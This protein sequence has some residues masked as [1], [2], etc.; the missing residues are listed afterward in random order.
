MIL[1]ALEEMRQKLVQ[2]FERNQIGYGSVHSFSSPRRLALFSDGIADRQPDREELVLGPA[3]SVGFDAANRPTSAALGFSRKLGIP[4]EALETVQSEKGVYLGF[5][6]KTAGRTVPEILAESLPEIFSE[7]SWPKTMYWRE[8]RFRFIRPLRWIVVLWNEEVLSF[9]FENVRAGR[10]TRGHRFLGNARIELQSAS[11][12]VEQLRKN[13]VLVDLNERREKI[14]KELEASCPAGTHLVP[15]PELIELVVN[16]NEYPAVLRGEF[17]ER[18]LAIPKEVLITV[19]RH[20]QKYFAVMDKKQELLP[21]FL[22]VLNTVPRQGQVI[23]RGHEK[24]LRA[25]LEDAEFFWEADRKITLQERV[26]RLE[27]VMFQEQ[28]GSYREKTERLREL[29]SQLEKSEDLDTAALLCKADLT[30]EMV[31]ELTELQGIMG[32]LYACEEG[33]PEEVWRAIYSHY[34][35]LSLADAVPGTRTG[36]LLSLADKIDTI[37]G[38]FSVGIIPSGSSDPFALRRQG[39]GLVK[40]LRE[41]RF[42]WPLQSLVNLAFQ[43]LSGSRKSGTCPEVLQFMERRLRFILQERGIPYDVIN[44]VVKSGGDDAVYQ[45]FEKA[46]ALTAMRKHADFLAVCAAYKRIKN[47]LDNQELGEQPLDPH[48]LRESE[49]LDLHR[50]FQKIQPKVENCLEKGEYIQALQLI[51]GLRSTVDHFFDKVLVMTEDAQLR[52]NRLRLLRDISKMFLR[53]GELSE[54]VTES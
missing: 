19:M 6:R 33:Y 23:K 2:V 21:F 34:R 35:P 25:R 37:V 26:R 13:Y 39:Q 50:S 53:M 8:S 20:H 49:E 24:V 5:R 41:Y 29:C 11:S 46:E 9:E 40:I 45:T 32:G 4:M 31:R 36:A 28:L 47:I 3:R 42:Q 12:Y 7:I 16:L 38:C 14:E 17:P 54:I 52:A 1:P 44:A 27:H 48:A 10:V 43:G 18:F 51:A 15:D 22:T 30:T